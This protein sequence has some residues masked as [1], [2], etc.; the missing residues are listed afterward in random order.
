LATEI[1]AEFLA[2][3]KAV[4][5]KRARTVIDH[6]LEHGSITTEELK[7]KYGYNHPPRA[8]RD[9]KEQGIP[10]KMFRTVG[11]D[12]R[13]IS[14]YRFDLDA[15][16]EDG[17]SGRKAIPKITKDKLL[18]RDGPHCAV[19]GLKYESRYLQ[20]D[21]CVPYEV[22]GET[23]SDDLSQLMLV[24]GSCNRGKSWSCE[25]CKNWTEIKD[26]KNCQTCYWAS[27]KNYQHIALVQI[28]RMDVGWK[29][30]EVK[31]YDKL[32]EQSKKEGL[33]VQDLLKRIVKDSSLLK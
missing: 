11:N 24:C 15:M 14:A 9:V 25:H 21:H 31:L 4:K 8:A 13:S 33:S 2:R 22:A 17:K 32:Q 16:I 3:L 23:L 29:G 18:E 5:A 26:V 27:P 7:E 28:R 30:E 12:G 10:I 20:V 19:C 6:I 1:P